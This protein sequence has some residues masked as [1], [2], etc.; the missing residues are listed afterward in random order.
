MASELMEEIDGVRFTPFGISG[1][2]LVALGHGDAAA[3]YAAFDQYARMCWGMPLEPDG[4]TFLLRTWAALASDCGHVDEPDHGTRDCQAC[5]SPDWAAEYRVRHEHVCW[6]CQEI[7]AAPW[8]LT[9]LFDPPGSNAKRVGYFPVTMLRDPA[10]AAAEQ[11]WT[12][13]ESAVDAA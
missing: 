6:L 2:G 9:G 12:L 7:A 8:W 5:A 1:R 4:F 3:V 10:D 13:P 11:A